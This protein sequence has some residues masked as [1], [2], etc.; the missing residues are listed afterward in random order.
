MPENMTRGLFRSFKELGEYYAQ[1]GSFSDEIK[2][3]L[4]KPYIMSRTRIALFR[5]FKFTGLTNF[6]WNSRLKKNNAFQKRF[7]RPYQ[8]H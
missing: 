1:T 7:D 2:A 3:R 8:T 4:G 6:Y 5:F